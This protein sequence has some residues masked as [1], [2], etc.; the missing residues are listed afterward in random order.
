[1]NTDG[2]T[3]KSGHAII[4]GWQEVHGNRK[5][6]IYKDSNDHLAVVCW[7]TDKLMEVRHLRNYNIHYAEDTAENW[8]TRVIRKGNVHVSE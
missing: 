1:M 2:L 4:S 3:S 6:L 8:V 5:A 7:E